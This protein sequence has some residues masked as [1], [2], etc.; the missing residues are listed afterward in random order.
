MGL[1]RTRKSLLESTD[2][3]HMKGRSA[4]GRNDLKQQL[5]VD[6]GRR[7]SP[8]GL[9]IGRSDQGPGRVRTE[10][11]LLDEV[12]ESDEVTLPFGE[13]FIPDEDLDRDPGVRIVEE[14]RL[15]EDGEIS[16][17]GCDSSRSRQFGSSAAEPQRSA[18]VS[19]LS[20]TFPDGV[21]G[22]ILL[23]RTSGLP[24]GAV[25]CSACLV[26]ISLGRMPASR[27]SPAS[28]ASSISSSSLA[29]KHGSLKPK[30]AARRRKISVFGS[31]SPNGGITASA[32]CSQ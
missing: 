21:A 6:L 20:S 7:I 12:T 10:K 3:L 5:Q 19:D 23:N 22:R 2:D 26:G 28:T 24:S 4:L 9:Q 29:L 8:Q 11:V 13:A 27:G 14:M 17:K 31:D 15:S 18:K 32:R 30:R 25:I 1:A 16:I